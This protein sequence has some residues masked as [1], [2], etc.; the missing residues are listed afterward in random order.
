MNFIDRSLDT[1]YKLF[2]AK[3]RDEKNAKRGWKA[4]HFAFVYRRNTLLAIGQNSYTEDGRIVKFRRLAPAMRFNYPHAELDCLSKLWGREHIDGSMRMVVVRLNRHGMLCDSKPCSN[5][6]D[7]L[8][9]LCLTDVYASNKMG[10][11]VKV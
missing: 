3:Y 7:V 6:R 11:I 5:C 10:E 4:I 8:N 9:A 1:A 2:P